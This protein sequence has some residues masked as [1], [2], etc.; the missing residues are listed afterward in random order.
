MITQKQLREVKALGVAIDHQMAFGGKSK[1]NKHLSRV[2]KLA[3]HMAKIL[4]ADMAIVEAGAWLHD[5][6]LPTGND[7]DY[8]K[9]KKVVLKLL[10]KIDLNV[11]DKEQIAECVAAHEG[12]KIPNTL[13]SKIVHDADVLEKTGMLGI[14]RHTWK[15]TNF[16]KLRSEKITTTEA[17]EIIDHIK[18][19]NSMLQ[20]KLG[21]KI[22]KYL[23]VSV[24]PKKAVGIVSFVSKLAQQGVITEKI[25]QKLKIHLTKEQQNCLRE[26][27]TQ[28]YLKKFK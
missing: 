4:R 9:N 16:S 13:E 6:A 11:E 20:T 15:M 14:I 28:T 22:G 18:W 26:Q 17:K 3:K 27:L 24:S 23:T 1:G 19:R 2:V 21:K 10:S 25:A 5:T 12:T 8:N 7:Y